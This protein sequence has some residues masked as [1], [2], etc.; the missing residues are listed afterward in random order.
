MI[1]DICVNV[2]RIKK[3]NTTAPQNPS[4]HSCSLIDF[5]RHG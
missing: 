4:F 1:K 3:W 5:L 2:T